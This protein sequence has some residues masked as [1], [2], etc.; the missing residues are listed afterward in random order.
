M[1]VS[2]NHHAS[3]FALLALLPAPVLAQSS[4]I[5]VGRWQP[6]GA[7]STYQRD[8]RVPGDGALRIEPRRAAGEVWSSGAGLVIPDPLRAGEHV[9]AV[10]WARAE[11]PVRVTATM[12]G[13]APAYTALTVSPIDLTPGWRRYTITG[14]APKDLPARSQSLTVQTG[15]AAVAVSLGPVA[16]LPGEPDAAS[17][18]NAFAGFRARS[19]AHDVRISSDPG[20]VLAGTLRTP[21]GH[22]TGPFA[23]AILIQGHGPNGRGGYGSLSDRLLADGIATLEY[24]K[25]GIGA[26]TG[27]Y[28]EDIAALTRDARAWV[29]AMRRRPQIDG[30]RIALV[31]HSQG[32][33]I[34]PAVAASDPMIKAVVTLAGSVGDG[35][36]YLRRAIHNQ[37]IAAGLAEAVVAPVVD[38]AGT[39]LQARSD[40]EDAETIA[41][42]RA[43]LTDRFVAAGFSR[44]RAEA[45]LSM[46]DVREAWRAEEMRSASD[47][48]ALQIPVLAVFGSKDPLV[49]ASDEAPEARRALAGNPRAKVV[50]LEGLSHWF[51]EGAQ[52][53]GAEEVPKLGANLG[54]PRAVSLAGDWLRAVLAPARGNHVRATSGAGRKF[55]AVATLD[56]RD[57]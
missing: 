22:G 34:A 11:R 14:L 40:G 4:A 9:S 24:D 8:A 51:Q 17:V 54:S 25:R 53:G 19:V 37:M 12:N 7:R 36:P 56:R 45:A 21:T 50:V 16:F 57:R 31:G 44:P 15:Q 42:L 13:A 46:I 10:F 5:E 32:G 27:V 1:I 49:I 28:E 2:A 6:Y 41:R 18:R 33:V 23:L 29:T 55:P 35:L 48:R 30:R 26:S 47:L 38:A 20:V 39:L 3:F 52:T 43:A